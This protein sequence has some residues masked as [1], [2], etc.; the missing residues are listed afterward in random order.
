MCSWAISVPSG[1]SSLGSSGGVSDVD[2]DSGPVCPSGAN[3]PSGPEQ[4]AD[5]NSGHSCSGGVPL[6]EDKLG[7]SALYLLA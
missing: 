5:E 7:R 1:L 2:N 4:G 3:K 6:P